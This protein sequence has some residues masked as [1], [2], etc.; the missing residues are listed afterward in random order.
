MFH[1][2]IIQS[3]F[4]GAKNLRVWGRPVMITGSKYI[5]VG[6]NVEFCRLARIDAISYYPNTGQHFEP[7]LKIANNVV[8]QVSCHIGCINR[9]E[10]GEYTT[11]GARTYITDHTH[12]TVEPDDLKLP[13]RHRKLYSKGPVIIGKYVAIGEGCIILPGVTIGDHSVIGANAVVTKD[14]PP[15]SVVAGNPAKVIKQV[16]E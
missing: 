10:I 14:V 4:K 6:E 3:R 11:M 9:V 16:V 7:V 1:S 12:G 2:K 8:V 15:Y 13:P 5:S